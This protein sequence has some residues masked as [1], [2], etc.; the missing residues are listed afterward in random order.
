MMV[1]TTTMMTVA[2]LVMTTVIGTSVPVV[3]K[4]SL[5]VATKCWQG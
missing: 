5:K 1:V 2:I 3:W 4:V